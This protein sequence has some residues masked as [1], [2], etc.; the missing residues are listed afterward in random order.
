V[1]LGNVA[2]KFNG[3][4]SDLV[5]PNLVWKKSFVFLDRRVTEFA[6]NKALHVKDSPCGV[7][8][9]LILGGISHEPSAVFAKANIGRRNSVTLLIWT[10]VN[11]IVS[12]DSHT[13]VCRSKINANTRP[14]NLTSI[15]SS[16]D[17]A[18]DG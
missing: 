18:D 16:S 17:F 2:L 14:I 11:S 3:W 12:P 4:L 13:R 9:R 10:N 1:C 7:L 6:S 15:S 8:R 5:A